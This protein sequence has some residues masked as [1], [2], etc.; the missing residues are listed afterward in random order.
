MSEHRIFETEE[1]GRSLG[2]LSASDVRFVEA[3]L[4]SQAYPQL[5]EMPFYGRNIKKLRDYRP[6]TWRYRLGNYRVFFH[7]DTG[8]KVVFVLTVEKRGDAYR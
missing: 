2:K 8:A 5:R 1:F 3:K 4:Q 6:A 7:V